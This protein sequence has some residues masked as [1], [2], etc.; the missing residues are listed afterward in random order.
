MKGGIVG[1]SKAAPK[2]NDIDINKQ[3]FTDE[4]YEEIKRL[5]RKPK[6][7]KEHQKKKLN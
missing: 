6:K 4:E 3:G 2:T 5:Q 1:T 7:K